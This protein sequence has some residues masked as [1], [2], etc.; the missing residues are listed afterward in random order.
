MTW[1]KR[2]SIEDG[3]A[4]TLWASSVGSVG[5]SVISMMMFLLELGT[6]SKKNLA[7]SA[8]LSY[9]IAHYPLVLTVRELIFLS[10]ANITSWI[11]FSLNFTLKI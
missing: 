10:I 1:N 8:S 9:L 3:M 11:H 2:A 4:S 6:F 5:S 7:L